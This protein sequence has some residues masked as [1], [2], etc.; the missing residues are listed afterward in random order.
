MTL[1][2]QK[3]APSETDPLQNR[4]SNRIPDEKS[5]PAHSRLSILLS[6]MFILVVA[7]VAFSMLGN[8]S[9]ELPTLSMSHNRKRT[10]PKPTDQIQA[11]E[12]SAGEG[13]RVIGKISGSGLVFKD[14]LTVE[15]FDDPKVKGVTLYVSNFERPLNGK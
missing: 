9:T 11:S 4:P 14:T 1:S 12:A 8:H 15:S 13:S 3:I 2:Q 6:G 5:S 7:M 10:K